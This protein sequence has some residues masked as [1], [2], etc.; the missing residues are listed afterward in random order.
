[1]AVHTRADNKAGV[2]EIMTAAELLMK[3]DRPHAAMKIL[4]PL[5]KKLDVVQTMLTLKNLGPILDILWTVQPRA[6]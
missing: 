2:A 1:M 4:L 6:R 3:S 5:M